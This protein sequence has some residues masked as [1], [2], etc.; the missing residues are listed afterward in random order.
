MRDRERFRF[1]EAL[2]D[3]RRVEHAATAEA[4]AE[5]ERE[6]ERAHEACDQ[7]ERL[8]QDAAEA[9]TTC[10]R[11]DAFDPEMAARWGDGAIARAQTAASETLRLDASSRQLAQRRDEQFAAALVRDHAAK[12]AHRAGREWRRWHEERRLADASDHISRKRRGRP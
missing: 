8:A 3:L 7:A 5:A 10:L 6:V 11:T 1:L 12:A 4:T 9:W 2:H